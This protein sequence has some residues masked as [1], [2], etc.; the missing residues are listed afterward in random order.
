MYIVYRPPSYLNP[1]LIPNSVPWCVPC[2]Y[3]TNLYVPVCLYLR[4]ITLHAQQLF[5]PA[6]LIL[7]CL[8]SVRNGIL[9]M[10][11]CCDFFIC[12][13]HEQ[14]CKLN[15]IPSLICS[16]STFYPEFCFIYPLERNT[17]L[18]APVALASN[19]T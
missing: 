12:N 18:M 7:P 5:D 15:K 17:N 14:L 3:R 11:Q 1:L 8:S 9:L 4:S 19:A 16:V 10:Q 2:L 13:A 6:L